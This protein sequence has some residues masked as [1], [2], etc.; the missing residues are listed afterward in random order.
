MV[1]LSRA[2][3]AQRQ[4]DA[5][6]DWARFPKS[7]LK[8]GRL[9]YRAARRKRSPWWFCTC[10]DCRFDLPGDRGT[11]YTGTDAVS[12]LLET[13]GPELAESVPITPDLFRKRTVHALRL[14]EPLPLANLVSRRAVSFRIT[15]ELSSMTPYQTPQAF[16]RVFDEVRNASGRVLRGIQFRTRFDTGAQARGVALFDAAGMRDLR[17]DSEEE[18]D[19]TMFAA[20]RTLGIVIENPPTLNELELA[21]DPV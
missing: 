7:T 15:N 10:G 17:S 4:P 21:P 1:A 12:G 9:L 18:V 5:S 8:P 14:A 6:L 20:L 2:T 13:L 16:A 19:E 3:V 11:C